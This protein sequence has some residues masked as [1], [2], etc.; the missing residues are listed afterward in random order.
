MN[1]K[2]YKRRNFIKASAIAGA[3]IIALPH[4]QGLAS[5]PK[6]IKVGIIGLD[7]SHSV[8]FTKLLNAR[9]ALAG[10][11]GVKVVAAYPAKGSDIETNIKRLPGFVARME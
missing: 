11:E 7:T 6:E 9:P 10:H 1:Q 8:A 4:L 2:K 5:G 3:G